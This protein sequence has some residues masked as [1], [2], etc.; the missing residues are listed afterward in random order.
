MRIVVLGGAGLMGRITLRALAEAPRV[1]EVVIADLNPVPGYQL[2]EAIG[3]PKLRVTQMDATDEPAL[4]AALRGADVCLNATVY[5]YNLA[6]MRA[7]LAAGVHY[8]DLGGLFHTTRKQ[9]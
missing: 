2:V 6:V 3:S 1:E 9:L 8:L 5:Y 4:T 7:C